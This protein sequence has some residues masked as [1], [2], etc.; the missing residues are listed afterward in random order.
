MDLTN[1]V[2][3]LIVCIVALAA[4][5][6]FCWGMSRTKWWRQTDQ[7]KCSF[8]I[9]GCTLTHGAEYAAECDEIARDEWLRLYDEAHI[10]L[11]Q[12]KWRD[13]APRD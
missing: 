10:T 8:G 2:D 5:L 1:P 13:D 4:W 9:P 12:P 7:P 11:P 3:G 6:L